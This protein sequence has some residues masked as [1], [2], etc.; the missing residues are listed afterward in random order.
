MPKSALPA[1]EQIQEYLKLTKTVAE[2]RQLK[3]LLAIVRN[4]EP[5]TTVDTVAR[6]RSRTPFR[7]RKVR[8]R[9]FQKG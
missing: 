2:Y 1:K 4:P 8:V 9:N 3:A 7:R 5:A 6:K